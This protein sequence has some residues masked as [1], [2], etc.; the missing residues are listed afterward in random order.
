MKLYCFS[1]PV[2]LATFLFE[3]GAAFYMLFRYKQS[4]TAWLII[5]ILVCLAIFQGAE[6]LVCGGLG[7]TGALWSK[8]GYLAITLLPPLG[9][10]LIHSI[11]GRKGRYIVPFAYATA[12]IYLVYFTFYSGV[13]SG[14][15][16]YA[17]YV[18]FESRSELLPPI[19]YAIYYYGWMI[20]GACL[21]LV[22][23]R[24]H[25]SKRIRKALVALAIGYASFIVPT[26]TVNLINPETIAG[27]PSI[28]CG[29]A[30]IFAAIMV[31]QIAPWEL[32]E[33][34]R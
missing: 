1:P 34:S 17:N 15:T 7:L 11:S 20:I 4:K 31:A 29:F 28:M 3:I 25:Q 24:Q 13:I 22:I 10:H 19:L 5:A 16:C 26:T 21:G 2:M 6:Y 33:K 27:I 23:A 32:E 12:C 18:V 30:V 8:V 14:Q 9:L